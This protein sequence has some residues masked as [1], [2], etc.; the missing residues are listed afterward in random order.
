ME[1]EEGTTN[2]VRESLEDTSDT[3]TRFICKVCGAGS[4]DGHVHDSP[5]SETYYP[6]N[7]NDI[8]NEYLMVPSVVIK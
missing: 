6:K 8:V 4:E 2:K 7:N 3:T 1:K 5:I